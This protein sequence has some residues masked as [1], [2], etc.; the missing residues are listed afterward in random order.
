MMNVPLIDL[1][2]STEGFIDR[3]EKVMDY[4]NQWSLGLT[5]AQ[6]LILA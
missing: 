2:A 1:V 4:V 3:N 5:K 6:L